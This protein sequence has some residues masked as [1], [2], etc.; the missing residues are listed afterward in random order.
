MG[1]VESCDQG[2]DGDVADVGSDQ[3]DETRDVQPKAVLESLSTEFLP[4][5]R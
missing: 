1:E 4:G 5:R 2:T 3:I